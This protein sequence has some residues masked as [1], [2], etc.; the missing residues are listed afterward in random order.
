MSVIR[1]HEWRIH[2]AARA[3]RAAG[4]LGGV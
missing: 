4:A 1:E 3:G 2:L